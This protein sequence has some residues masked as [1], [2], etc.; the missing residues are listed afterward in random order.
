[1]YQRIVDKDQLAISVNGGFGFSFDPNLLNITA[2]PKA[3]VDPQAVEKAVYEELDRVK[4]EEVTDQE[5]EK[6]KNIVLANFY[7]QMSTISGRA[8][9]LGAYEVFFGDYHKLFTAVDSYNKVT[10]ADLQ[11]V[12]QKYFGEKNRTVA[13]LIPEKAPEKAAEKSEGPKQ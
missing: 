10:K 2:Q 3:G 8:N 11:R 9:T 13:T 6:A 5:I 7:R 1:M 12:A 4:K